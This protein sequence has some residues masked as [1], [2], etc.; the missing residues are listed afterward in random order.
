MTENGI[1]TIIIETAIMIHRKL[2]PGLFESVYEIV[3][4]HELQKRGLT[5]KRQ[6]PVKIEWDGIAFDEGFRADIL[7]E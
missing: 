3:L 7:V 1:G 2:G 6:V 4:A 5:A